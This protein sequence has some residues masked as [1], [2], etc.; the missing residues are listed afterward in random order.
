MIY[1]L[2]AGPFVKIGYTDSLRTRLND[3]QVGC[4]YRQELVATMPGPPATEA[5]L[6]DLADNHAYR[7]EWFHYR[8]D[9]KRWLEGANNVRTVTYDDGD[10]EYC[11]RSRLHEY[12][13]LDAYLISVGQ[14]PSIRKYSKGPALNRGIGLEGQKPSPE[15]CGFAAFETVNR[16]RQQTWEFAPTVN[17]ERDL[18]HL[19]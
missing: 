13:E 3:L 14:T 5:A 18:A 2:R 1:F 7:A 6:H 8:G 10:T 12:E 17:G 9:L 19:V 11:F 16:T 4:P 15:L